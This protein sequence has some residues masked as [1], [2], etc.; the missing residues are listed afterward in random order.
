MFR[1]FLFGIIPAFLV[2]ITFSSSLWAKE[3][4]AVYGDSRDGH[5]THREIVQ[6]ILERKPERV[7]HTGDMV[8]KP[9]ARKDWRTFIDITRPVRKIASFFAV[10]GN[11]DGEPKSFWSVFSHQ[12]KDP[13][14][15]IDS[16]SLS[17][18][19]LDTNRS[20]RADSKQFKW[21]AATLDSAAREGKKAIIFTHKPFFSVSSHYG[22]A[23]DG[24]ESVRDLFERYGVSLVFSGH[25]HA[26][27][28]FWDRGTT[29]V[30]TGGGGALLHEK[31][32]D[33]PRL[34]KFE[35]AYHFCYVCFDKEMFQVQVINNSNQVI[36]EFQV[37]ATAL[38]DKRI[39]Q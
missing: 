13:W 8:N 22:E 21:L 29:Y 9:K 17:Y 14:F 4:L 32:V 37:P 12:S 5:Q 10:P 18:V 35:M 36:E 38:K 2:L 34:K 7:F 1:K 31:E 30:V 23:F 26:Y 15:L 6:R 28:R 33:D 19:I 24:Q 3:C 20:L 16:G 39:Q 25:E 27:E 11:H